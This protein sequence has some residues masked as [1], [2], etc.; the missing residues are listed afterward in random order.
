LDPL[1]LFR[2][3]QWDAQPLRIGAHSVL[4]YELVTPALT[5]KYLVKDFRHQIG[6]KD[7]WR[8]PLYRWDRIE[9]TSPSWD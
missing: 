5:M 2:D 1:E 4:T 3:A 7:G 6:R 8:V 9:K